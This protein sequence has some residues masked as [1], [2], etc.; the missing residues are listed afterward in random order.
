MKI[1]NDELMMI[2]AIARNFLN[3]SNGEPVTA[4]GTLSWAKDVI[5]ANYPEDMKVFR[6]LVKK[7][8]VFQYARP[9]VYSQ[10]VGLT[11][12]GYAMWAADVAAR[13][14][15]KALIR[16]YSQALGN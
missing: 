8:L 1:T 4:G 15:E 10:Q 6:S 16:N 5:D 11:E 2:R 3:I 14:A 9:A 13:K 12:E 7:A